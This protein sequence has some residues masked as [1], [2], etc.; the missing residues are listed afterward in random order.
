IG[1]AWDPSGKGAWAI[2]GGVGV[3]HNW[4][5]LANTQEEY[6]GNPPGLII[7]TFYSNAG[8][9][10]VLSFGTNNTTPPFGY[11]YPV[12]PAASLD[13]HGGLPGLNFTVGAI[14]PNLKAPIVYNWAATVERRIGRN[15]SVSA[16]YSGSRGTGLLSAGG[17]TTAVSYGADVNAYQGDLIEHNSLVP[18]RLNPSFGSILYTAND[19]FSRYNAFIT[20]FTGRFG[21]RGFLNFSYTRSSSKDDTQYYPSAYDPQ[22]WFGPSVWDVP[23]RFSLTGNYEIRG[24]Q[25]G[26]GIVGHLTGGWS[27]S[28]TAIV[29]SGYPFTVNTTA[30]FA[31]IKNAAGQFVGY[32]PG[33]GDYNADGDNFDYPDV[34]TYKQS[35]NRQDFLNSGV[36]SVG[37][38]TNP[39][40]GTEGNEKFGRFRNPSFF[41]TDVSLGK[42]TA[43]FERI[44]LQLRFDFFNVFNRVNLYS[45]DSNL[46]SGT[47]GKALSQYNPRWIQFG[48]AVRF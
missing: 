4:P 38:F 19:R 24:L 14:D 42:D 18:T 5:T 21:G 15:Y 1:A 30:A 31:P 7:P 40:F 26:R 32:A 22:R 2:R 37:Q 12:L 34:S 47:F 13:A 33:S 43:L 29:Q 35:T 45:V 3:Y 6:R 25:R 9:G 10:P 11:T 23:N 27:L 28:G 41:N 44:R 8:V 20:S 39:A 16:G 36:F 48:A 46:S 17:Q